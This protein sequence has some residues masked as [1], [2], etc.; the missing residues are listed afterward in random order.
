MAQVKRHTTQRVSPE[1]PP[2]LPQTYWPWPVGPAAPPTMENVIVQYQ[3]SEDTWAEHPSVFTGTMSL[4][5]NWANIGYMV[6]RARRNNRKCCRSGPVMVT[7]MRDE[8]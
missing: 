4:E 1:L 8:N 7:L 5:V 3:V 6:Q 2:P